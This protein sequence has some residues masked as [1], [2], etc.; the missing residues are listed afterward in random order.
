M[1]RLGKRLASVISETEQTRVKVLKPEELLD[2]LT[3]EEPPLTTV[4]GYT[5][6][7]TSPGTDH[8]D[9]RRKQRAIGEL[10]AKNARRLKE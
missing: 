5:V 3:T 2:L 1:A 7:V 10:I 6:K 9:V 8:E 4:R